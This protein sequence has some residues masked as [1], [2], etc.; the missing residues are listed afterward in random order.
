MKSIHIFYKLVAITILAISAWLLWFLRCRFCV[1]ISDLSNLGIALIALEISIL[2]L[3]I[4]DK[5]RRYLDVHAKCWA[6]TKGMEEGIWKLVF[7]I[8][9]NE[10][11]PIHDLVVSL[12]CPAK[13]CLL[14]DKETG[15]QEGFA[16]HKYGDTLL[17]FSETIRFL[18][19]EQYN[20]MIKYEFRIDINNWPNERNIYFTLSAY[21]RGPT[22]FC[23]RGSDKESYKN[24]TENNPVVMKKL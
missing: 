5:R 23:I 14:E 21:E 1:P 15:L 11:Y 17:V 8:Y 16:S 18:S 2:S 10:K 12:R 6:V 4:A 9:N 22:T 24:A 19:T 13:A 7:Q 20:N 3:G